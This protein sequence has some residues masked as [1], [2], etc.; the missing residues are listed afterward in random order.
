MRL[1][2]HA[3]EKKTTVQNVENPNNSTI[4]PLQQGSS[5]SALRRQAER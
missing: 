4:P 3:T 2:L 5:S 1:N